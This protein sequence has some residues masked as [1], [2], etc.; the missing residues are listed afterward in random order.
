L[1]VGIGR[2]SNIER[3]GTKSICGTDALSTSSSGPLKQ[4]A[5][6]CGNY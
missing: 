1:V 6:T 3:V 2:P 5:Q 4:D